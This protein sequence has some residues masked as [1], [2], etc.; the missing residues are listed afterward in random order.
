MS[1]VKRNERLLD[2]LRPEWRAGGF[3]RDNGGVAFYARVNALLDQDMDVLDLGAGRGEAFQA[4][5]FGYFHR[6]AKFQGKVKRV[7]GVDVDEAI[8]DHPFLD[9]RH[10]IGVNDPFPLA[11]SSIDIVVA[12]WVFEHIDDPRAMACELMR[13]VKPGGWVCARTPNKWGYVGL[14]ARL[15]PNWAH[16]KFLRA[17]WPERQAIDVFPTRYRLNSIASLNRF[18]SRALWDNFSYRINPTP[19]YTGNSPIL[20]LMVDLIQTVAPA[21]MKTDLIVMLRKRSQ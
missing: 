16:A 19:K 7:I 17:L 6:L 20:F 12:D 18:F 13:V 1:P 2:R 21:P 10:V 4:D 14:G 3:A 15:L 9:E 8:Q 5:S 11:D